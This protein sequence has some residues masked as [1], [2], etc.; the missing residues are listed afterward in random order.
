MELS[1]RRHCNRCT[2]AS[3][4]E[5]LPPLPLSQPPHPCSP[6]LAK[7]MSTAILVASR[8][9]SPDPPT[10]TAPKPTHETPPLSQHSC[11]SPASLLSTSPAITS[12][13]LLPT[14][15]QKT[16]W[17]STHA[18]TRPLDVGSRPPQ[19]P[20]KVRLHTTLPRR[21]TLHKSTL[22]SNSRA[23]DPRSLSEIH[24]M[25]GISHH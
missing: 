8:P 17:G 14:H 5:L 10:R 7:R 4:A 20:S 24:A 2:C 9:P 6:A 25:L 15:K 16:R 19:A 18:S 11:K 22:N 12:S 23:R 13:V 1:I 21:K 3:M